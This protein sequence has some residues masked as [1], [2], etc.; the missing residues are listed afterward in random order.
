MN[1]TSCPPNPFLAGCTDHCYQ[2]QFC[3]AL[4]FFRA[5]SAFCGISTNGE[6]CHDGIVYG[7]ITSQWDNS[8]WEFFLKG[9]FWEKQ[10][11][12]RQWQW[13]VDLVGEKSDGEKIGDENWA[14]KSRAAA[15][16]W[17]PSS[18]HSLVA[19]AVCIGCLGGFSGGRLCSHLRRRP[20]PPTVW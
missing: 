15:I 20:C 4:A 1:C 2:A 14:P 5:A 10:R 11:E 18:C 9:R 12:I 6:G 7:R 3:W 8:R 19:K 16:S 17:A 13:T